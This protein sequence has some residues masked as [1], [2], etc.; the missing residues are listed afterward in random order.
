MGLAPRGWTRHVRGEPNSEPRLELETARGA[1]HEV[2]G[3][4]GWTRISNLRLTGWRRFTILLILRA[5]SSDGI[6]CGERHCDELDRTVLARSSGW[7]AGPGEDARVH[8]AGGLLAGARHHGDHGDLQR[9]ARRRA[10]PVPVQGRRQPDE[11][12]RLEP[13]AA[14]VHGPAT[15]SISSSRSPSAA[16]SSRASSP[17]RSATCC[18]PATAI[19]SGCA[20]TTAR[21]TRST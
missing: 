9:A 20:A 13:G 4:S 15:R 17:R 21:S 16:R 19:R 10:R 5:C 14:R 6:L 12:P 2:V 7:R 18:G 3:S 8:G 11:R 1:N